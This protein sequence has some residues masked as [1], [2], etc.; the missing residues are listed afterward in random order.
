MITDNYLNGA[1]E[2]LEEARKEMDAE[3]ARLK[4][5]EIDIENLERLSRSLKK[6]YSLLVR[7]REAYS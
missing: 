3:L 7:M 2:T 4:A 1:I 5:Q 6:A